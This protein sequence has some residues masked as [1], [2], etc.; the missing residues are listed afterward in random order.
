ML[1]NMSQQS[2]LDK[3]SELETGLP[4]AH[5]GYQYGAPYGPI[6]FRL[7]QPSLRAGNALAGDFRSQ[8]LGRGLSEPP[9]ILPGDRQ[10]VAYSGPFG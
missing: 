5:L 8:A 4:L 3:L 7:A 9:L 2:V 1:L 6:G 10:F